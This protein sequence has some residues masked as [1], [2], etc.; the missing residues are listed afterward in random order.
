MC[1]ILGCVARTPVSLRHELVEAPNPMIRQ[2]QEHDSGW[3]MAA[4]AHGDGEDP[5]LARFPDAAHADG[6]FLDATEK[7]ARIFNVHVR[8][9]TMGG[10]TP[11]NTHP[12]TLGSYSFCHNGTILHFS[13]L[14]EPGVMPPAGETDSEHFFNLLMRDFDDGDV[15]RS[16]RRAVTFAIG[17]SPFSGLNFLFSDGDRLYAYRLGIFELH[18]LIRPDQTLVA[19]ERITDEPWHS[20]EQDV[21]ITLDP[22]YPEDI[23]CERLVG[24]GVLASATIEKYEEGSEL[25]GRERGDFAAARAARLAAAE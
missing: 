16:L 2:S 13:R 14:L 11:E 10:L 7:H 17:S 20:V 15:V 1:R 8:R 19:S 25:R 3:G 21:L 18:W 6:A 23:H 9:A 5:A 4:Y 12:F 22:E 24:D